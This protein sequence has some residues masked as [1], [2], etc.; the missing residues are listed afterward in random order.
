MPPKDKLTPEALGTWQK[1]ASSQVRNAQERLRRLEASPVDRPP[2]PLRLNV[3]LATDPDAAASGPF[4][5]QGITL[6][7]A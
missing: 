5:F 4:S 1:A 2:V 6:V 3:D 7:L